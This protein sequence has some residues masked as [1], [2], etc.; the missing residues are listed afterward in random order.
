MTWQRLRLFVIDDD[1]IAL[2]AQTALLEKAGHEVVGHV[3]AAEALSD[4]VR[5]VP[6]GAL[7]DVVMGGLDR[8][9]TRLNSSHT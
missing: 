8:K 4:M 1:D 2:R 9:S 7:V 6:D 3:D 5:R